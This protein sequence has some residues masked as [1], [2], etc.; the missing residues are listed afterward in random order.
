MPVLTRAQALIEAKRTPLFVKRVKEASREYLSSLE[1]EMED[2]PVGYHGLVEDEKGNKTVCVPISRWTAR[3][4]Y[5]TCPFGCDGEPDGSTR[6][7]LH[8]G[9]CNRYPTP[10]G[11][12]GTRGSHCHAACDLFKRHK[13]DFGHHTTA[14]FAT[15][16][17]VIE[18]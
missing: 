18:H 7:H 1:A 10:L 4:A 12:E 5:Y 11:L 17:T 16:R 8:G 9:H 2:V 15:K 14:L 6:I 3:Q 13:H